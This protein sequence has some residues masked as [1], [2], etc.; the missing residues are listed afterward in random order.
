MHVS[1]WGDSLAVRISEDVAQSLGLKE[2]DEVEIRAVPPARS[3]RVSEYE[4]DAMIQA[5]RSLRGRL[6]AEYK[7][8]REEANAR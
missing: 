8:D 3:G 5:L 6:P 7:F 4:R 1:K 2:G